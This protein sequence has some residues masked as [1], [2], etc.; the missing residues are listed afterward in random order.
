MCCI[1]TNRYYIYQSD[2]IQGSTII[3]ILIEVDNA[4]LST[5]RI[6]IAQQKNVKLIQHLNRRLADCGRKQSRLHIHIFARPH[7]DPQAKYILHIK[8]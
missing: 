7:F 4:L 8:S 5:T 2:K 3:H 6:F 1:F